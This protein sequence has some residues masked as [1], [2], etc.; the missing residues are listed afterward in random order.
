MEDI[1]EIL[2][3]FVIAAWGAINPTGSTFDWTEV[4][5]TL[6]ICAARGKQLILQVSYKAFTSASTPGVLVP[7]DLE[8]QVDANDRG[9][10]G[11]VHRPATM[12]RFIDCIEAVADRYD[13]NPNFE[14]ICTP[15]TSPSF[16]GNRPSDYDVGDYVVELKRLYSAMAAAFTKSNVMPMLNSLSGQTINQLT[17][18]CY[19]LGIGIG[20]PD[21]RTNVVMWPLFEGDDYDASHP[22]VRDYRGILPR[23]VT[24]SSSSLNNPGVPLPAGII[25]FCQVHQVTHMPWISYSSAPGTTWTDCKAAIQADPTLHTTCPTGYGSCEV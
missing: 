10:W 21:A 11:G 9:Y 16:A 24:V 12:T 6:S 23:C 20:G 14:M 22:A 18:H 4:D 8:W 15:E 17:E 13:D 1:P 2:G 3:A 5:N 25:D 7:A 19:D